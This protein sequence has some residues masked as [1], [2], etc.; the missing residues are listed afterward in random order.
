MECIYLHHRHSKR[1]HI[2]CTHSII[3]TICM[4][5]CDASKIIDSELVW[6]IDQPG[7]KGLVPELSWCMQS[8]LPFLTTIT[9]YIMPGQICTSVTYVI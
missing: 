8:T 7:F 5:C 9:S 1:L 3:K 6:M 4:H 2:P